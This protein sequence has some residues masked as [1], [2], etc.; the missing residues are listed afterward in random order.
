MDEDFNMETE[1]KRKVGYKYKTKNKPKRMKNPH[2]THAQIFKKLL[3]CFRNL[4]SSP[5]MSLNM[6]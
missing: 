4:K 2:N 1:P 5:E 3:K 6:K